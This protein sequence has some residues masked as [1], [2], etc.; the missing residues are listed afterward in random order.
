[1]TIIGVSRAEHLAL[2]VI[3]GLCCYSE[4]LDQEMPI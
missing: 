4:T 3:F 1:M 2:Q